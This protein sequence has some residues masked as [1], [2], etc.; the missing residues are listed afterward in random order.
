MGT[1]SKNVQ[2]R[3]W[4]RKARKH[5]QAA[6]HIHHSLLTEHTRCTCCVEVSPLFMGPEARVLTL[7]ILKTNTIHIFIATGLALAVLILACPAHV[8]AQNSGSVDV[9]VQS[10]ASDMVGRRLVYAVKE[11]IRRSRGL[12][13]VVPDQSGFTVVISTMPKYEDQPNVSTMYSVYWLLDT[14]ENLPFLLNHTMGYAGTQVVDSSAQSIVA[15]TDE[16]VSQIRQYVRSMAQ[17]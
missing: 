9:A 16:V 1:H 8:L 17:Y 11:E 7:P 15:S 2:G 3:P 5:A 14:G 4:K 13:L 12:D 10:Q 6:I